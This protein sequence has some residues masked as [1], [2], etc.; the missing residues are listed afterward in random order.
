MRPNAVVMS[1][2]AIPA[3]MPA[4]PPEALWAAMPTNAFTIPIV[5]PRR[6]T[7]GAVEPTVPSTPSP[8]LNSAST[9]SIWRSTARSAELMSAAVMV[10]RSRSSG[11]TSDSASPSTRATCDS[12]C[13]S[14]SL[15]AA[16]ICSSCRKR[17]NSGAN[18]FVSWIALR[19]PKSFLNVTLHD[20]RDMPSSSTTMNLAK[21]PI[22][23]HSSTRLIALAP[24]PLDGEIERDVDHDPHRAAVH[25]GGTEHTPAQRID[26]AGIEARVGRLQDLDGIGLDVAGRVDDGARQHPPLNLRLLEQL[27]EH[28]LRTR[29]T[30]GLL[31]HDRGREHRVGV[32]H[33]AVRHAALDARPGVVLGVEMLRQVDLR[34]A[35]RDD[36][37]SDHGLKAFERHVRHDHLRLGRLLFLV[38]VQEHHRGVDESLVVGRVRAE[39]RPD[40]AQDEHRV[41]RHGGEPHPEEFLLLG[42][43]ARFDQIVEHETTLLC[44]TTEILPER[45]NPLVARRLQNDNKRIRVAE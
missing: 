31:F 32:R 30:L 16:S 6:P 26:H 27:G 39:C 9:I 2:S 40:G 7:N 36:V 13:F 4:R 11:F 28:G 45:P 17:E 14:A 3:E 38:L 22:V 44:V 34:D 35:G 23:D 12:F 41:N 10:A 25:A 19:R 1:A 33:D 43:A 20:H 5:V 37:R 24:L 29:Q 8:R 15:M 42:L 18:F 21:G